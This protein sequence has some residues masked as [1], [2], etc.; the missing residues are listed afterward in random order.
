[1][2]KAS[3]YS[4]DKQKCNYTILKWIHEQITKPE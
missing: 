2:I 3:L 4:A 1:M